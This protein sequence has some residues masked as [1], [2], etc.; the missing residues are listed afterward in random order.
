MNRAHDANQAIEALEQTR[1]AGFDQFSLDLIFGSPG[2][3]GD[4]WK[5]S[6]NR[7]LLQPA[8]YFLLRPDG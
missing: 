3:S 8:A 1:K 5:K 7:S 2:L 6:P 4:R